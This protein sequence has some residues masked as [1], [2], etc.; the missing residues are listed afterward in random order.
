VRW[1]SLTPLERLVEASPAEIFELSLHAE[2]GP[3]I[4][5]DLRGLPTSPLTIAEGSTVPP[6]VVSAGIAERAR[7]VWLLPTP[8]FQRARLD[9]RDVPPA[10]RRRRD[11]VYALAASAIAREAQQHGA[12]VMAVDGSCGLDEMVAAVEERFA[13]A[14]A[15]GPHA[16]TKAER[17]ALVRYSNERS[18]SQYVGYFAR[19]PSDDPATYSFPFECECGD[20]ECDEVVQVPV[21]DFKRLAEAAAAPVLAPRH[22]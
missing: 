18:A 21:G 3:M 5:D 15:E 8:E 22:G 6:Y 17:Q 12:P 20:P 10:V 14:L 11:E 13:A 16:R 1:E 9:E 19:V 7:T 4:V 2:R